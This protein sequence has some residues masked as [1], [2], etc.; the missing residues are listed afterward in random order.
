V[1]GS[2]HVFE[3]ALRLPVEQRADLAAEL[4]RSLDDDDDRQA[5]PAKKVERRWAEEI[6]RRAERALRGETVGRDAEAV[7][8]A[9]ESKLRRR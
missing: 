5:P 8:S 6:T 2:R 7:L 3:E 1:I 4:L 9:V